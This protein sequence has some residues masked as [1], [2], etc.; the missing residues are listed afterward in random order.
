[1]ILAAFDHGEI[2]MWQGFLWLRVR[3]V[4]DKCGESQSAPRA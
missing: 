4:P 3:E 2:R 1:M